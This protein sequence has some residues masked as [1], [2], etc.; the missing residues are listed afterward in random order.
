ML[1]RAAHHVA[2]A[3]AP[4]S[5]TAAFQRIE[6][7]PLGGRRVLVLVVAQASQVTHK[8]VELSEA[9]T[10]AEFE[11]AAN[12]LNGEF[13]G[14][15]LVEVRERIIER[16]SHER[17]LYD[18]LMARALRL[19]QSGFD[20]VEDTHSLFVEGASSLVGEISVPYSGI[21]LNAIGVLVQM[22][23]EKRRL[24]RLL[25]EYIDSPGLTVVIGAE[26]SDPN[27][28][29]FSLVASTYFDGHAVGTVG[30]IGPMR[31]HYARAISMVDGAAQAVSRVLG[32]E[33]GPVPAPNS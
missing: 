28:R 25:S 14:L 4:R 30:L 24:V 20:Q 27:L 11:Q 9:V 15:P 7:V 5:E 6:F 18:K 2:F 21:T 29:H 3:L 10:R 22:I 8:V 12:Y 33:A 19:A 16:L 32:G 13:S 1:A 26:H 23:E 31:M 17:V